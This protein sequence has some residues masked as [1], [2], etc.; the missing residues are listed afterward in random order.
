MHSGTARALWVLG[1]AFTGLPAGILLLIGQ[2]LSD[3]SST[4]LARLDAA[5]RGAADERLVHGTVRAPPDQP[6]LV[7]PASGRRCIAWEVSVSVH[8]VEKGSDGKD[9]RR[10]EEVR[11]GGAA[12]RFDVDDPQAGLLATI[13]EPRLTWL[14][15]PQMRREDELPGWAD[16]L[17][18]SASGDSTRAG[19][20]YEVSEWTLQPGEE[21]S[22]FG[23]AADDGSA[24]LRAPPGD[25]RIRLFF[26]SP[27]Q[28]REEGLRTASAARW[29]LLISRFF[30]GA[31]GLLIVALVWTLA[32]GR[33][34]ST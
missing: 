27:T 21:V 5:E 32:R 20:W 1:F 24:R 19:R 30:L 17:T 13:E 14:R 8:W 28:W 18:E 25:G 3:E 12:S 26:G 31:F 4:L 23:V 15:E 16:Q 2:S 29:V 22:F 7:S 6:V 33:L 10:S 34:R 11:R 9:S